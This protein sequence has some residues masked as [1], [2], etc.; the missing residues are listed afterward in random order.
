MAVSDETR[1]GVIQAAD[2]IRRQQQRALG[3]DRAFRSDGYE[4]GR[5]Q[6][7]GHAI[8][9]QLGRHGAA[10]MSGSDLRKSLTKNNRDV[11]DLAVHKLAGDGIVQ[12]EKV[13]RGERYRL[14]AGRHGGDPTVD[15]LMQVK[16]GGDCRHGGDPNKVI[17]L[18]NRRSAKTGQKRPGCQK[19]F[20]GYLEDLRAQGHE[21]V[22]A[23]AVREAGQAAGYSR[24]S[25]YVAA[26]TRGL[27]GPI[28]A[29]L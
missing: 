19:W 6:T 12:V 24:N 15:V 21:T 5:I 1:R 23:F 4:A 11:F 8:I 17:S 25:L 13:P 18:E 7:A 14:V 16:E 27:K 28:W 26:N 22:E 29:L 2:E 3:A 10:G 9:E 20:D